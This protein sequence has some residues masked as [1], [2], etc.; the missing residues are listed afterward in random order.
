MTQEEKKLSL[1][2]FCARLPHGLIVDRLGVPR[3]VLAINSNNMTLLLDRGEY[4]PAWYSIDEVK[5][6][7]HKMSSMTKEE[8]RTFLTLMAHALPS[9]TVEWLDKNHFDH[10]TNEDGDHLID[11]GLAL[12]AP[13]DMYKTEEQQ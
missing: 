8:R 6:Y 13:D 3:K 2:D 7:L 10:R 9:T 4:M 1:I 11:I 5:P 12:K